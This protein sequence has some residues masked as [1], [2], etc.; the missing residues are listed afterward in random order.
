MPTFNS[1]IDNELSTQT[2]Q[3]LKPN[4]ATQRAIDELESGG[5]TRYES[6]NFE[7]DD[8]DI[9]DVAKQRLATI[10]PVKVDLN[11]L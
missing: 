1:D 2:T 11:D 4:R 7:N 10:Q 9:I 6:F 8:S 5:G 3:I